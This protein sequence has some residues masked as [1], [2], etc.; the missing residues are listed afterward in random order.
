M[1][2]LEVMPQAAAARPKGNPTPPQ[3]QLVP[4]G[5]QTR[6]MRRMT[7]LWDHLVLGL[8]VMAAAA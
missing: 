5:L 8:G 6:M 3:L 4:L 2:G 1:E 7:S